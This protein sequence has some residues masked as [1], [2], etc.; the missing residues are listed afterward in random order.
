MRGILR[1]L[2]L[3]AA[4]LLAGA[5]VPQARPF[6]CG[7]PL[8]AHDRAGL[9]RIG[10]ADAFVG[11]LKVLVVRLRFSDSAFSQ[12]SAAMVAADTLVARFYRDNSEGKLTMTPRILVGILDVG[13]SIAGYQ[14]DN[15]FDGLETLLRAK[16]K[17]LGLQRPRDY[18]RLVFDFPPIDALDWSGLSG[19]SQDGV[20]FINGDFDAGVVAHELGHTLDLPHASALEAG[21]LTLPA[22]PT[23]PPY[24]E[25]GDQFDVMGNGEIVSHFNMYFKKIL[26]WTDGGEFL[27][28]GSGTFRIYAHDHAA[29]S[30]KLLAVRIP[31][32]DPA[33][34]YWIEYRNVAYWKSK[35]FRLGPTIRME[36]MTD[37]QDKTGLLDMTPDSHSSENSDFQDAGLA[38]GKQYH[39][40]RYGFTL[41]TLAADTAD[42]DQNGW[43]DVQIVGNG[44]V[45]LAPPARAFRGAASRPA[46]PGLWMDVEGRALAIRKPAPGAYF[47][48][49]E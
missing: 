19:G 31:T 12:D 44:E 45:T 14:T 24:I 38:V 26:G 11:N 41:K 1:T 25:Y 35:Q 2:S 48:A 43:V 17:A 32:P 36:G 49:P 28:A 39:D 29:K 4:A 6:K 10:A 9:A 3:T 40:L 33:I 47:R 27:Q 23:I 34:A 13:K 7:P 18:D 42:K 20:S 30:G 46:L 22:P 8:H 37:E 16:I 15:S 5:S 21:A